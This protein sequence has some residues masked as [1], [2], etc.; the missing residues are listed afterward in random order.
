MP[1]LTVG[2]L[3]AWNAA[4]FE[5][6]RANYEEITPELFLCGITKLEDVRGREILDEIELPGPLQDD[7]LQETGMLFG[8]FQDL[9]LTPRQIRRKLRSS[10][11]EG[12]FKRGEK[13]DS[14]MHRSASTKEVFNNALLSAREKGKDFVTLNDLLVSL[15]ES[16]NKNID[17]VLTEQGVHIK[18][19][20]NAL[21]RTDLSINE[22]L[23]PD[24]A[25]HLIGQPNEDDNPEVTILIQ[26][27]DGQKE[28]KNLK[29][30]EVIIG[31]RGGDKPVDIDLSLDRSVSRQHARLYYHRNCWYIVDLGSAYGTVVDG[32][33]LS[34]A[35]LISPHSR[36]QVGNS[37]I[38]ISYESLATQIVDVGEPSEASGSITDFEPVDELAPPGSVSEDR[39]IGILAEI[40]Q[41]SA[42]AQSPGEL[43]EGCIQMIREAIPNA[44]RV[45][46]LVGQDNEMFPVKHYPREQAYYSS[47]F[48]E[49]A[50]DSKVA[51]CWVS[52]NDQTLNKPESV[53]NAVAAM[54][55]PMIRNKQVVGVLHVDSK[56][57]VE[58]FSKT[59]LDTLSIIGNVIALAL[60]AS[61]TEDETPSVFISYAHKDIEPVNKLKNDLRRNGISVWIDERL[62]VADEAWQKQ[63][64]LAIQKQKFFL[65][66]MTP[67]SLSSPYCEWEL[68]TAQAL[69]KSIIPIMLSKAD[70]PITIVTLQYIPFETDY[71]RSLSKLVQS[72]HA[73]MV[74]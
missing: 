20:V 62:K 72:I 28:L 46:I 63:L 9:G 49:K 13:I 17:Q 22:T 48:V 3:M 44:E 2:I 27:P 71:D 12:S 36:I 67:N 8:I 7:Y 38:S 40:L 43:Y 21:Q 11:G 26:L 34:D 64:A 14:P 56:S 70:V 25:R 41:I 33:R 53:F 47:T 51:F 60:K 65:F 15:L 59:E 29:Q 24:A 6:Y 30:R 58:G 32:I 66:V 45:T 39:R 35:C 74:G 16:G 4:R 31:R 10:I 73:Q 61:K 54:Y 55:S 69:Q 23:S 5:T 37:H 50:R 1:N 68:H 19:L 18:D 42:N 57:L 52:Q